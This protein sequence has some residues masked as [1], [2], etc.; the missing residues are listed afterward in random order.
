MAL[1]RWPIKRTL[2]TL[3]AILLL[4]SVAA[5]TS[6]IVGTRG[7]S[8]A[9]AQVT[10]AQQ[11]RETIDRFAF[12]DQRTQFLETLIGSTPST[13]AS[14]QPDE[15]RDR[16]EMKVLEE[17]LGSA[18]L[19]A[20]PRAAVDKML[21]AFA[22]YQKWDVAILALGNERPLT[23]AENDQANIDF[24][25]L[26]AAKNGTA[27]E[28][29]RQLKRGLTQQQKALQDATMRVIAFAAA[30]AVSAMILGLV[31]LV[32]SRQLVRRLG[33]LTATITQVGTGDLTVSA[34][35]RGGD[36]VSQIG[37]ALNAT[38]AQLRQLLATMGKNSETL[39]GTARELERGAVQMGEAAENA[40]QTAD[41][42]A[43]AA[44]EVSHNVRSVAAGSVEMGSSISEIAQNA[45]EA[46]QVAT[47]AVR[48]MASTTDKMDQLGESSREI[49]DVIRLI[50]SIAEQTNLLALNATIEAARA[51]SAGKGFAVVAD[52]VKQL[53]QET[54]RATKDISRRVEAIQQDAKEAAR[55]ISEI[56]GVIVQING[57]QTTI[58]SAVEEQTATTRT[59]N[60]GVEEAVT[61]SGRIA[62][63]I[64]RVAEATGETAATVQGAR[65]SSRELAV[66]GQELQNLVSGYR[67]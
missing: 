66:M 2:P 18:E 31:L 42:A 60:E 40:S 13:A 25:A 45:N 14:V 67:V 22:A 17:Q 4:V 61:G 3:V 56:A 35:V 47:D 62:E 65:A 33:D 8:R 28:A 49:G 20:Q 55:S 11:I 23:A 38:S 27:A 16:A 59:I 54:A 46:A 48:V 24:A 15:D 5:G 6:L 51:G 36:E 9:R 34:D 21:T 30:L 29:Q 32:F 19:A 63:N 64:A 52:E 1:G 26:V 39:S 10:H 58:A 53:S 44:R 50:T 12:L 7:L 37:M 57:F 41:V 43:R